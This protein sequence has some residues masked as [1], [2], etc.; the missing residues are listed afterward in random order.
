MAC[1]ARPSNH[2][3]SYQ[4][5]TSKATRNVALDT[6]DCTGYSWAGT[7]ADEFALMWRSGTSVSSFAGAIDDHTSG[8]DSV[9]KFV[10]AVGIRHANHRKLHRTGSLPL[11]TP[12]S[13]AEAITER[14]CRRTG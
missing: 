5:Q 11:I 2:S 1:Q 12:Y 6:T 14:I 8:E 9:T 13:L 4:N 7:F 10:R 3:Q